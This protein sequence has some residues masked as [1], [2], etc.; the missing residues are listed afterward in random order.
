MAVCLQ[1]SA[2]YGDLFGDA[3]LSALLGEEASIARMVLFERK[4]ALVQGELGVIPGK[5][6]RAI[7]DGLSATTV[8]PSALAP[9]VAAS[10]V[11]IPAL[12]SALREELDA[13]DGQWLHWGATSQDVIDTAHVLGWATALDLLEARIATLL[14]ALEEKSQSYVALVMAARTRTQIATPI[15]FGLRV[16]QWAAPLIDAKIALPTLRQNVMKV[17][18]G[19]ASGA[20]TAIAPTGPDTAAKLAEALGLR[21]APPW[22][23]N[24]S[25]PLALA[26]WALSVATAL[27]KMARDMLLMVRNDVGEL[28]IGS[29]GGSSTMPQKANPV[30]PETV[31]A[32]AALVRTAQGALA[33]AAPQ[34]EER[35][36]TRWPLEWALIPHMLVSVGAALRHATQSAMSMEPDADRIAA[37]LAANTGV[38]AEQ[39][40]FVLAAQMPRAEAQAIVRKAAQMDQPLAQALRALA[41]EIDWPKELG[42]EGVVPACRAVSDEI[43][44]QR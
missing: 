1:T 32:L 21:A 10:G 39:A 34:A 14:D 7:H 29:G 26:A 20:N 6:A 16:A 18:F 12:V 8:T 38:M 35:D 9:G 43:W 41:P 3:E 15:T 30:G 23:S 4:L 44:R 2:L 17:Q 28:R 31:C 13:S 37:T 36:G 33:A 40:S 11:P 42:L 25:A 24:R 22:H 19:G 5:A 27:E